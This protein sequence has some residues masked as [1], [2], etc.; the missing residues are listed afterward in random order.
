M[1]SWRLRSQ[2]TANLHTDSEISPKIFFFPKNPFCWESTMFPLMD[3]IL[4]CVIFKWITVLTC[5]I[6]WESQIPEQWFLPLYS[7]RPKTMKP[8]WRNVIAMSYAIWFIKSDPDLIPCLGKRKISMSSALFLLEYQ[9]CQRKQKE[10]TD[11]SKDKVLE[12]LLQGV[13]CNILNQVTA[14][15]TQSFRKRGNSTVT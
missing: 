11:L 8:S 9:I 14:S 2:C 10:G 15:L 13:K 12:E 6:W 4:C 3:L 5:Y 1:R 7:D